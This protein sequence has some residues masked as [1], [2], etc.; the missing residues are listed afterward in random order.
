[1]NQKSMIVDAEYKPKDEA[2]EEVKGPEACMGFPTLA[3]QGTM[4]TDDNFY[5][6]KKKHKVYVIG[7]TDSQCPTC[8]QDEP[9]L[10]FLQTH[11]ENKTYSYNGKAIPVARI[12]LSQNHKF[13]ER[14]KFS[15][16]SLPEVLV[17]FNGK[18]YVYPESSKHLDVFL[19]FLNRVLQ[20]VVQLENT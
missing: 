7:V 19:H 15:F 9:L 6:F 11:L 12:D 18:F 13:I 16:P 17:V 1:M 8:C 5:E 2:K 4:L 3:V 10:Y 14:E 20:P